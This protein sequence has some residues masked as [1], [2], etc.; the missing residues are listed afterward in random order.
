MSLPNDSND[1]STDGPTT[2]TDHQQVVEHRCDLVSKSHLCTDGTDSLNN[3]MTGTNNSCNDR[4]KRT[5]LWAKDS[6]D[7]STDGLTTTTDNQQVV[8]G[9]CDLVSHAGSFETA[10]DA[11]DDDMDDNDTDML[12]ATSFSDNQKTVVDET[13]LE[14]NDGNDNLDHLGT[15]V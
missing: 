12:T 3:D 5:D 7:G 2:T 15:L 6:N 11:S 1:G 10:N 9:R 13:N 8:Q 14:T 4:F